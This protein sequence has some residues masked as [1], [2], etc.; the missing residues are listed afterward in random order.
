MTQQMVTF[1]VARTQFDKD[2]MLDLSPNHSVDVPDHRIC[3][4][5]ALGSTTDDL[6]DEHALMSREDK[7]V[8]IDDRRNHYR[9]TKVELE[10][11]KIWFVGDL[12]LSG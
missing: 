1:L 7:A 9:I 12:V 5:V 8:W 3:G 6:I 11:A 10:Q 4:Y 2:A